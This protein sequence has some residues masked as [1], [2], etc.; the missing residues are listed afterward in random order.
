MA[1]PQVFFENSSYSSSDDD[2]LRFRQHT[3]VRQRSHSRAPK[4]GTLGVPKH[5]RGRASSMG[6]HG[7]ESNNIYI[8]NDN[9]SPSRERSHSH[10][11]ARPRAFVDDD[12]FLG[13]EDQIEQLRHHRR[14]RSTS[15]SP[16]V[17]FEDQ[18]RLDRL[19]L[20]ER[21][22]EALLEDRAKKLDDQIKELQKDRERRIRDREREVERER[23]RIK[24]RTDHRGERKE[25]SASRRD[26]ETEVQIER[27]LQMQ[28]DLETQRFI[29]DQ[30]LVRRAQAKDEEEA[31]KDREKRIRQKVESERAKQEAEENKRKEYET[32]LKKQAI[33]DYHRAE[34]DRK[35][36]EEKEKEK[37]D[38]E[39]ETR[40]RATLAKAGYTNDQITAILKGEGKSIAT[41]IARP[42]QKPTYIKVSHHHISPETLDAFQIPWE[43]DDRDGGFILIKRMISDDVQEDLFEHT[44]TLR[45]RQKLLIAPPSPQPHVGV[46]VRDRDEMFLVRPSRKKSPRCGAW[47]W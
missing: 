44:R 18:L 26:L 14:P 10:V 19:R 4:I 32:Q 1:P 45:D 33:E 47:L 11:R 25:R 36:R 22:E 35:K 38:K 6:P 24:D 40:A 17:D 43:W 2:S 27:L 23:E 37:A 9:R 8:V 20:V 15:R 41:P 31:E 46:R 42:T 29:D 12:V 28:H 30:I 5:R 7:R 3:R 13:I 21:R 34:A 39:F 16:H